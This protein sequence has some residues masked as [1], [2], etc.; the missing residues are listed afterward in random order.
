MTH[1]AR[2]RHGARIMMDLKPLLETDTSQ[3]MDIS[4]ILWGSYEIAGCPFGAHQT[5]MMY[6]WAF[7]QY[8]TSN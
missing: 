7:E 6:W 8:T 1:Y 5:G 4:A 3:S 2:D